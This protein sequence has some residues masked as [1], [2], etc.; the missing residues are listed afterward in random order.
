MKNT[1]IFSIHFDLQQTT[2]RNC[3]IYAE[4]KFYGRWYTH[5]LKCILFVWLFIISSSLMMASLFVLRVFYSIEMKH[6]SIA[7]ASERWES[8]MKVYARILYI[9]R[10]VIGIHGELKEQTASQPSRLKWDERIS[11]LI[12]LLRSERRQYAIMSDGN[13]RAK[14]EGGISEQFVNEMIVLKC[15]LLFL[16]EWNLIRCD[17]WSWC[18]SHMS[19][20]RGRM[21]FCEKGYRLKLNSRVINHSMNDITKKM[22]ENWIKIKEEWF[23]F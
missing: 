10:S 5:Y 2:S 14:W 1:Y 23:T 17:Y 12:M 4:K 22:F 3:L 20:R 19:F 21:S 8:E 11:L 18:T 9:I 7:L 13:N 15:L 16:F 6:L